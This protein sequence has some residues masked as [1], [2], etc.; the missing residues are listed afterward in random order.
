MKNDEYIV[1]KKKTDDQKNII[2]SDCKQLE[3]FRN[4]KGCNEIFVQFKDDHGNEIT[5]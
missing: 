1:M 2:S 3:F 5:K 4:K